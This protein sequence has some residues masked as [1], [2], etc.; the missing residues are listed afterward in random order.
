MDRPL[1]MQ[2]IHRIEMTVAIYAVQRGPPECVH[3][4]LPLRTKQQ[5]KIKLQELRIKT[6]K[7]VGD[8]WEEVCKDVDFMKGTFIK[9]GLSVNI[10]GS[11]DHLIKFDGQH[12]P[13]VE[14][15]SSD[16]EEEPSSSDDT[17]SDESS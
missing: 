8:A 13:E 5:V 14:I 15:P 11:E 3:K 7:W 4:C 10:N 6:T 2:G 16:A 17:S 9:T 12:L 1:V